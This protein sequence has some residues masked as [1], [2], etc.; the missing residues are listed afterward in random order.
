MLLCM[1]NHLS[2][3]ALSCW[4]RRSQSSSEGL[5]GGTNVVTRPAPA[6]GT[7]MVKKARELPKKYGWFLGHEFRHE[8]SGYDVTRTEPMES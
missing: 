8:T 6:G 7:G 2:T 4:P 1:L 5:C 3:V